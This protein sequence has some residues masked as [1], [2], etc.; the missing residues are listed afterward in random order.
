MFAGVMSRWIT[1]RWCIPA[2]ARASLE[3]ETGQVVGGQR[4][5]HARQARLAGVLKHDR[6]GRPGHLRQLGHPRDAA[7]PL[8]H[9]RLMPQPGGSASGPSGSL[10]MTV[11]SCEKS[12]V[13][14]VRSLECTISARRDGSGAGPHTVCL[15]RAHLLT[16]WASPISAQTQREEIHDGHLV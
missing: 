9:R 12:L 11:R 3:P 1:P 4:L 8:Q 2:T 10:R 14:R 16:R 6:P 13:M 5:G 7:Q 15:H